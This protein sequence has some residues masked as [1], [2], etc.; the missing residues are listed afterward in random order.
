M[1]IKRVQNLEDGVPVDR[2]AMSV[3]RIGLSRG[4]LWSVAV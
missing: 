1:K 3:L 4:C 2:L